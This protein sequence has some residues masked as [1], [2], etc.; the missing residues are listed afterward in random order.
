[1][2]IKQIKQIYLQAE[3]IETYLN[4]FYGAMAPEVKE[5]LPFS[6][7]EIEGLFRDKKMDVFDNYSFGCGWFKA[8]EK[9]Y[10]LFGSF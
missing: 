10:L 3:D 6:R 1:M 9:K 8:K 7:K 2:T 4:K 5:M